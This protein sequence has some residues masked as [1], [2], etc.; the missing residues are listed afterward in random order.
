MIK[1]RQRLSSFAIA[2]LLGGAATDIQAQANDQVNTS[3]TNKATK[4]TRTKAA[5][6]TGLDKA[7]LTLINQGKWNEAIEQLQT[8][9]Q[10]KKNAG[11]AEAWLAFA[12]LYLGK[13][14]ELKSLDE[15][16]TAR[17]PNSE[18]PLAA[19]TVHVFALT[20]QGKLQEA[21]TLSSST[22]ES[23]RDLL[24]NF[25]RACVALKQ[26][27]PQEAASWCEKVVEIDPSF[28][29]GY[30]TLG[31]IQEKSLRNSGSAERA[32]ERALAAQANFKEVRNLLTD[33]RLTANDFD[34]AIA[35]T[36][37]AIARYPKDA[38]NYYRLAQIYSQQFRLLEALN[39]LDNAAKLAKNDARWYRSRANIFRQQGKTSEA[40]AEQR[41][42]V[43]LG[44]DSA[45]ELVELARLQELNNDLKDAISSLKQALEV[46][47]NHENARQKLLA[48]LQREQSWSELAVEYKK[49]T[50]LNPKQASLRLGL[51]KALKNSGKPDEAISELKE[52]ANLEQAN[53][54]AHREIAKIELQRHKYREAAKSYTRALNINPSSVEDLVALGYCYANNNDWVQAE[55]AFVTGLA[56]HQLSLTSGAAVSVSQFDIMRSLA[57]V[58]LTEGRYREA[59]LNLEAVVGGD[60]NATGKQEDEFMMYQAQALRDRTAAAVKKMIS[61]YDL[62]PAATRK[63]TLDGLIDTL[64]KLERRELTAQRLQDVSQDDLRK[65][66]PLL[67]SRLLAAAGK[68]KEAVELARQAAQDSTRDTEAKAELYLAA[69]QTLFEQKEYAEAG[70]A[71]NK[72]IELNPKSF[73]AHFERSKLYLQDKNYDSALTSARK[74]LEINP[75]FVGGYLNAGDACLGQNKISEALGQYL[76]AV[77]LYPNLAQAHKR[78]QETYLKQAKQTD[79]ER[80][81]E[82]VR[83]LEKESLASD[84]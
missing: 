35:I 53:P 27:K 48:L 78:L 13:H 76:K 34:G 46:N 45:F 9:C 4:T 30:R 65:S 42:A 58:L 14:A 43:E 28:A 77:E 66:D 26:G 80:E 81:A 83:N 7:T 1:H 18:D 57:S 64:G 63:A 69:A 37:D 32:Y 51:A 52:A 16:V 2:L 3:Q 39:Q 56:L 74:S 31:F 55:T 71:I 67:L 61:A 21:A 72:A 84:K 23:N 38:D 22:E 68:N 33:L 12:Y 20:S 11:K 24:F 17:A 29:W 15:T 40:I 62:L 41:K 50:A 49:A 6:I 75:Y 8:L 79:A 47:A 82:I 5:N 44:K 10:Q 25:A 59:A 70:E 54:V 73:Q 60:K 36:D 19:K